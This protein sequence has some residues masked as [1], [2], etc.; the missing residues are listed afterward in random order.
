MN[1]GPPKQCSWPSLAAS[2]ASN[3]R[4]TAEHDKEKESSTLCRQSLPSTKAALRGDKPR[5]YPAPTTS[6][7]LSQHSLHARQSSQLRPSFAATRLHGTDPA[8]PTNSFSHYQG[9]LPFQKQSPFAARSNQAQP[10]SN[11][12]D[13]S[14]GVV[15][16]HV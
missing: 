3:S 15:K 14:L 13:T 1:F 9:P 4:R 2:S 10:D 6:T 5:S 7:A 16:G 8:G 11:Q 12:S